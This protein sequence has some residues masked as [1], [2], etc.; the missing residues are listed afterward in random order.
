MDDLKGLFKTMGDEAVGFAGELVR[1]RSYTGQEEN[2]IRL[3]E[4]KMLSLGY[5]RVVVDGMGN[6]IGV[7]GSGDK[8]IMFDSHVDTVKVDDASEWT[9]DPFGGETKAG[10]LY[11]RGSA[12]MKSALAATVYAGAAIK[13]LGLDE[14]RTVYVSA[15]VMEEDYDGENLDYIFREDG[16]QPDFVVICEA[17]ECRVCLGQ[18]GRALLKVDIEGVSA[19]GSAPEKGLNPVYRMAEVIR[20]VEALNETLSGRPGDHGTIAL[21]R[22]ECESASYNAIP[23]RASVYLDRRLVTGETMEFV[24]GEM[25]T[26]LAGTGAS[27]EV[28]Q[29]IGKS[30]KGS[31]VRFNSFL[32]AWEIDTDHPL[33]RAAIKAC[34]R[35][36]GKATETTR[37]DFST[38]GVSSAR[39]GIPTIGY[40]PGD[41]K[42]AHM[43][44]EFC[45]I[46]DIYKACRFYAELVGE[47]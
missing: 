24:K 41:S 40:G 23:S 11:G 36:E 10:K 29:V 7:V 19:H 46:E 33:A 25:A 20:R 17:T 9:V 31:D 39:K 8:K 14:G 43:K 26:L 28:F 22:I 44:D 2:I 16:I 15:S 12:D 35:V 13:K 3:V 47:I 34:E 45:P 27:W 21:T 42:M 6:C 37:W 1:T 18:K 4:K 30:W 5:D 38:N 32:P